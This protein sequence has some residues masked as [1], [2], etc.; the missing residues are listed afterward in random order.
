[1]ST[2]LIL[3]T[4]GRHKSLKAVL[5]YYSGFDIDVYIL[6]GT[7]TSLDDPILQHERFHYF[8]F[9]PIPEDDSS[10]Q[11]SYLRRLSF[12][13]EHINED[14]SLLIT[15][16]DYFYPPS[17]AKCSSFLDEHPEFICCMGLPYAAYQTPDEDS[18]QIKPIYQYIT[19]FSASSP[20]PFLRNFQ[21]FSY[22]NPRHLYSVTRTKV[23]KAIYAALKNYA[24]LEIYAIFE[25]MI[26]ISLSTYGRAR[27]LNVPYWIRGSSPKI[28]R[29]KSVKTL[30]EYLA[31]P[32]DFAVVSDM[33]N[34]LIFNI[35]GFHDE[36]IYESYC[37]AISTYVNQFIKRKRP[38]S[39]NIQVLPSTAN[40]IFKSISSNF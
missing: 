15:D 4:L 34:S 6:D 32:K 29:T 9:E 10:P 13:Y 27:V 1:M 23:L 38:L 26:E 40:R 25:I 21:N 30:P 19:P 39:S 18:V 28:E 35:Y 31:Y 5:R 20:D 16:D 2:A 22:Y 24:D 37:M 17:I 7:S 14:H 12:A 8:H 11:G 33:M 36:D 3:P